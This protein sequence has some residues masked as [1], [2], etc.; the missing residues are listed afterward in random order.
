MKHARKFFVTALVALLA[1]A[2]PAF[3]QYNVAA[4]STLSRVAGQF[5]AANYAQWTGRVTQ[6]NSSTGSAT[7]TLYY[8]SFALPDGRVIVPFS[9]TAPITVDAGTNQETVTP[10]AVSNCAYLSTPG[11]GS[12]QITASFSFTHGQG[13]LVVSGTA[14][15]QE[16]LNDAFFSG[17]GT[18]VVDNAWTQAGGTNAMLIA[19]VPYSTVGILS[20]RGNE[21]T[22]WRPTQSVATVL[23][24]PTTLTATT[25]GFGINGANTSGGTYTGTSTYHYCIAYVDIMGNEGPCSADFSAATAGTGTTNQIGF[26]TPAASTGAVGYIPYISLASGSYALSYRALVTSSV[27]AL[28]KLETVIAACAVPNTTYG[29]SGSQAVVSA[30]TLNTSRIW[31]GTGGTSSTSDYVGNSNGRQGYAY[32]PSRSNGS[33]L[34]SA[35][36]PFTG[37]TAPA[38]TVPAVVGTVQ[39]PAGFMNYVGRTIRL[40]GLVKEA[41]AGSTATVSTIEFLWNADGS[42]T[43]GAGV[44]LGGPTITGTLVT[45]NADQWAFCQDLKTTVSGAGATAG[46]ILAGYGFL[47]ASYGAAT[48]VAAA[49]GPTIGAAAVGSLN[50][51]GEARIDVVYL[52]TTGTDGATPILQDLTAE[53]VN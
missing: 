2:L 12:C 14:G 35:S 39:L 42:N 53:V 13:A 43:A 9:V 8:G 33:G 15:L 48:T 29:Q 17:G 37:A 30:L 22:S 49:T 11:Y 16:A 20:T 45:S 52:H 21:I 24:A 28:T 1:A 38:T 51:A 40:C 23:S 46:S 27:C 10:T 5:V 32:A 3:P 4:E 34:V 36:L 31:L 47:T 50:L 25:V 19:A 7:I 6:G 26:A 18:V 44:I 41:S